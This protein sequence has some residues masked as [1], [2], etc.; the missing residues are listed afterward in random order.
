MSPP[1][2][3]STSAP[4]GV[5]NDTLTLT[6]SEL[7]NLHHDQDVVIQT[8][9]DAL[10]NPPYGF[11]EFLSRVLDISI[12]DAEFLAHAE[13]EGYYKVFCRESQHFVY[14]PKIRAIGRLNPYK[15]FKSSKRSSS[16][17]V[18][19]LLHLA[20]LVQDK[21]K[22][23]VYL[24]ALELTY[25]KEFS[26]RLFE[27]FEGTIRKAKECFKAFYDWLKSKKLRSK[28][29]ELGLT[30]NLHLWSSENPFEPH[31]HHHVNLL[32]LIWNRAEKKLIRFSPKLDA[33][34]LRAVWKDILI[35][36]GI[37]VKGDVDIHIRF[38]E[39]D[40]SWKNKNDLFRRFRYCGRSV[41]LDFCR[42]FENNDFNDSLISNSN[43]GYLLNLINYVNKRHVYGFMRHLK[44]LIDHLTQIKVECEDYVPPEEEELIVRDLQRLHGVDVCDELND[45]FGH[46]EVIK[47]IKNG[48]EWYC[49]ICGGSAVLVDVVPEDTI[50]KLIN[51]GVLYYRW[52]QNKHRWVL[53]SLV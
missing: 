48:N 21:I 24:I 15:K 36:H 12:E 9:S 40:N 11:I 33:D 29:E 22:K 32:N 27:D 25:P 30:E 20:E 1:Y 43:K 39:I 51:K 10:V 41:I 23:G 2:I 42:Y 14:Y 49:P 35:K 31:V 53:N 28:D 44:E 3:S 34:E 18:K 17:V 52:D 37:D 5:V 47:A 6:Q 19:Q 16:R 7:V 26:L 38:I 45:L 50:D 46:P 13:V 8:H 4:E